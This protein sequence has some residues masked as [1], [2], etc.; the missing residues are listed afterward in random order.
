MVSRLLPR[1]GDHAAAYYAAVT[2][3][4]GR[5]GS[6]RQSSRNSLPI[7]PARADSSSARVGEEGSGI[8]Y[9]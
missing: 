8:A 7:E 6:E 1:G 9:A 4:M 3:D 2:S 5:R